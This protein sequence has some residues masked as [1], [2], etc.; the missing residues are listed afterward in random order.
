MT[1]MQ[2]VVASIPVP[3]DNREADEFELHGGGDRVV[4][5][6]DK[7]GG[8][9]DTVVQRLT[10]LA[11]ATSGAVSNSA[12]RLDEIQ[13]NLGIEA[14]V[15]VG[16]VTKADASVSL[17]FTRRTTAVGGAEAAVKGPEGKP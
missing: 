5:T 3:G 14:G 9:W 4:A 2:V 1:E 8:V 12:F 11:T 13:F 16:L 7:L 15:A 10:V 17:T 6:I